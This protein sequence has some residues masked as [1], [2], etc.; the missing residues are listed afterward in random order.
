MISIKK[1]QHAHE[2]LKRLTTMIITRRDKGTNSEAGTTV[3]N[4]IQSAA[5]QESTV[6]GLSYTIL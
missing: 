3:C 2:I 1:L 5:L 4:I 6:I